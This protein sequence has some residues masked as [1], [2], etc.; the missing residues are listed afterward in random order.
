MYV[1]E[2][3][4]FLQSSFEVPITLSFFLIESTDY[5][6]NFCKEILWFEHN[7][8]INMFFET[9]EFT[10]ILALHSS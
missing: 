7:R 3:T 2:K 9:F 6:E 1:G 5:Y 8:F 4:D 10:A